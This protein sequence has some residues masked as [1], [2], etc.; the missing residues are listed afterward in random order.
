MRMSS[1]GPDSGQNMANAAGERASARVAHR[2]EWK[3]LG[4]AVELGGGSHPADRLHIWM[5]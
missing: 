3:G 5:L 2:L 1:K 4:R